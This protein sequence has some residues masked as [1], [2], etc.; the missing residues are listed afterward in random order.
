MEVA[1]RFGKD[2]K[3]P[4]KSEKRSIFGEEREYNLAPD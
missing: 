3:E 2:E 1:H 4:K